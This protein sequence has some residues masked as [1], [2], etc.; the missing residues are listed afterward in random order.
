MKKRTIIAAAV[1]MAL[2]LALVPFGALAADGTTVSIFHTNDMHANLIA[3]AADGEFNLAHVKSIVDA[4]EYALLVDAGD[5]MQGQSYSMLSNGNDVIKLMNAAGYDAMT[6]GNHEFDYGMDNLKTNLSEAKFPVLAANLTF[7]DPELDQL[8]GDYTITSIG[9]KKIA[10]FGLATQDTLST[11]APA[12]REGATFGDH[13]ESAK[14]ILEQL[15][16]WETENVQ[17]ID[18][19]VC[20][21]HFGYSDTDNELTSNYLAE[22][23][24]GID[25]IV[26]GHY[27]QAMMGA[28]AK[29]VGD[30]LIVSS[31]SSLSGLG[32]VDVTFAADGS[33]DMVSSNAR[34]ETID[35]TLAED[36]GVMDVIYLARASEEALAAVEIGSSTVDFTPD[37]MN[38]L[39]ADTMRWETGNRYAADPAY[40]DAI[41]LGYICGGNVRAQFAAGTLSFADALAVLPWGSTMEFIEIS[42]KILYEMVET[43]LRNFAPDASGAW[44]LVEGKGGPFLIGSGFSYTANLNGTALVTDDEAGKVTTPGARVT[45]IKLDDGTVLDPADE[46]T[47]II[48]ASSSYNMEGGDGYWCLVDN[49]TKIGEGISQEEAFVDYITYLME[50]GGYTDGISAEC[51]AT[52]ADRFTLSTEELPAEEPAEEQPA[53]QPAAEEDGGIKPVYILLIVLVVAAIAAAVLLSRKKKNDK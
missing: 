37:E 27:H 15:A 38:A 3:N 10:I 33:I 18:L 25:I 4:A 49:F 11:V 32:R 47:R 2:L 9:G 52:E 36:E 41:I 39:V 17:T 12:N 42:P 14:A 19:V 29:T 26:D 46:T 40:A 23:V 48:L 1:L 51:V 34:P 16:A 7:E 30:T 50:E 28:D 8:V 44:N 24:E 53:E 45:E 21:A 20:L 13:V 6:L 35:A 43:G 22:N 5:A 31:G